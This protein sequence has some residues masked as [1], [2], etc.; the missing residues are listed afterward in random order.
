MRRRQKVDRLGCNDAERD[1]RT[2]RGV[3]E[4]GQSIWTELNGEVVGSM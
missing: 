2:L 4:A 3:E 1:R